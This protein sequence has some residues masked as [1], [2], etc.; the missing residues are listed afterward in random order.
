MS[1]TAKA[2]KNPRSAVCKSAVMASTDI[3]TSLGNTLP[4]NTSTHK[5]CAFDQLVRPLLAT[6]KF[7]YLCANCMNV[8]CFL[9]QLLQLLL[10]ASQDKR[11]VCEEADKSLSEMATFLSPLPLMKK[12]QLYVK[13]TNLKVRAKAAVSMAHCVAKMVATRRTIFI[14]FNVPSFRLLNLSNLS[15]I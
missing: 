15:G 9:P 4:L 10:K 14:I 5:N 6:L 8:T 1:L 11:F 12:L 3:F 7:Y 13:H 2:M